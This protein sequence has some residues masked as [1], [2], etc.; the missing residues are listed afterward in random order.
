[1][2]NRA[3]IGCS[4]KT[5]SF[6]ARTVTCGVVFTYIFHLSYLSLN[7]PTNDGLFIFYMMITILYVVIPFITTVSRILLGAHYPSDCIVGVFQGILSCV[8]GECLYSVFMSCTKNVIHANELIAWSWSNIDYTHFIIVT[9]VGF[10]LVLVGSSRALSLWVKL[11]LISSLLFPSLVFARLMCVSPL[12]SDSI[13]YYLSPPIV[14]IEHYIILTGLFGGVMVSYKY[15]QFKKT[16][17]VAKATYYLIAHLSILTILMF[18]RLHP[19]A[20]NVAIKNGI[21]D[22]T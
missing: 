6:P 3:K 20:E 15:L 10:L 17:I 13:A 14:T 16:Q 12:A 18:H 4:D 8:L 7:D 21:G 22:D 1:M 9:T 5:S 11:P 2:I 19:P